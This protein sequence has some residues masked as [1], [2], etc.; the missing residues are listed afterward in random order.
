MYD[1]MG[2]ILLALGDQDEALLYFISA[3]KAY[4]EQGDLEEKQQVDAKIA[5]LQ[6]PKVKETKVTKKKR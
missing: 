4:E 1:H 6:N 5:R 2:D 3:R